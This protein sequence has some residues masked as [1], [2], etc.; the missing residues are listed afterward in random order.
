VPILRFFLPK[1]ITFCGPFFK[2]CIM[3]SKFTYLLHKLILL[4][5][6]LLCT[7][8]EKISRKWTKKMSKNRYVKTFLRKTA[9]R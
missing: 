8:V 1:K 7:R 6:E 2:R 5:F 9:R 4:F 3:L